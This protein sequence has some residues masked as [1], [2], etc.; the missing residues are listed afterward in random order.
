[1]KES[2]LDSSKIV[3]KL[4]NKNK[5]KAPILLCTIITPQTD[6]A[7]SNQANIKAITTKKPLNLPS[8]SYKL[9]PKEFYL[10]ISTTT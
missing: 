2:T 6:K 3:P 9:N 10:L 1:M 7:S 5:T 4:T 8:K